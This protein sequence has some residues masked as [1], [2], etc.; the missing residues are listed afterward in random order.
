VPL[1]LLF[2]RLVSLAAL[3]RLDTPHGGKVVEI[4]LKFVKVA[5][6]SELAALLLFAVLVRLAYARVHGAV[7]RA[8]A[9]LT[10]AAAT[11]Y[12]LIAEVDA[13]LRRWMGLRINIVFLRRFF[14]SAGEPGFWMQVWASL[15][16][17]RPGLLVTLVCITVPATMAVAAPGARAR[18]AAQAVAENDVVAAGRGAGPARPERVRRGR[19]AEVEAGGAGAVR[20]RARSPARGGRAETGRPTPPPA[21]AS[22]SPCSAARAA[23]S[24]TGAARRRR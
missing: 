16:Q 13:I 10:L 4:P 15:A 22:C 12:L 14:A 20:S 18:G 6:P 17:D 2:G 11:L 19:Q 3:Y 5:L 1:A 21:S 24:S 9:P 23:G 8:L 7:R